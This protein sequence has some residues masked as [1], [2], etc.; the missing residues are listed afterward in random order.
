MG[1]GQPW[2]RYDDMFS[3]WA[4]KVVADHLGLGSKSGAP[5]IYHNKASNP[6]TNLAKGTYMSYHLVFYQHHLNYQSIWALS[7][8]KKLFVFSTRLD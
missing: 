8:K 6:F 1:V 7:G 4:S 2:G 5:Y 3:G